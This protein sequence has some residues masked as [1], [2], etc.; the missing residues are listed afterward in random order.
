MM[1][2]EAWVS[3]GSCNLLKS[4][5]PQM[6]PDVPSLIGPMR[7]IPPQVA[8]QTQTVFPLHP[9]GRS[10]N[11]PKQATLACGLKVVEKQQTLEKDLFLPCVPRSN[12]S[13]S[14]MKGL[15]SSCTKKT[16]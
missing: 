13:V 10:E 6:N 12:T 11:T 4:L 14:F 16:Q 15:P 1:V 3:E 5:P 2:H 9:Q 7:T 8:P